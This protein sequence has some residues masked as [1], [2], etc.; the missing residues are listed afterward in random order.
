VI[1]D[2]RPKY[3]C[4]ACEGVADEGPSVSIAPPPPYLIPK[5]IATAGLLAYVRTAKFV[6]ALP[7]YRPAKQFERLG[8][9]LSRT[10][11]C[12]WALQVAEHSQPVVELPREQ[13]RA[14]PLTRCDE[15]TVQVLDEPGR[16]PPR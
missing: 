14:G 16:A 4:R 3:A 2:I 9:E 12:G 11:M 15:T 10:T 1:R 8:V 13:I 5:G 6:D 7:F